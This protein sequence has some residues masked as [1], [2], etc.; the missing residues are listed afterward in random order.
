VPPSNVVVTIIDVNNVVIQGFRI[1]NGD[2]AGI[3][4][5]NTSGCVIQE[6]I[7]ESNSR[8]FLVF[9]SQ[10]ATISNNGFTDCGLGIYGN[11]LHHFL[12]TIENN[13]VNSRELFYAKNVDTVNI[14]DEE[15]YGSI[16]L[17]NC[18]N[19]VIDGQNHLS[20]AEMGVELAF[21]TD[22]VVKNSNLSGN[23]FGAYVYNCTDNVFIQDNT[24]FDNINGMFLKKS[25]IAIDNNDICENEEYGIQLWESSGSHIE[26]N[27][28][29]NNF[30]AGIYLQNSHDNTIGD[31]N[32]VRDNV[33]GI[34]LYS[35]SH[36]TIVN[37][38]ILRNTYNGLFLKNASDN[39]IGRN[40]IERNGLNP[41]GEKNGIELKEG[42]SN[43]IIHYNIIRFSEY[44]GLYI[45]ENSDGNLIYHNVFWYNGHQ[46]LFIFK[47][48]CDS[49]SNTYDNGYPE[50]YIP[51]WKFDYDVDEE[52]G[53]YW[54]DHLS[55]DTKAGPNQDE[56]Y[57]DDICDSPYPIPCGSN[58]DRYPLQKLPGPGL[59]NDSTPPELSIHLPLPGM[60]YILGKPIQIPFLKIPI[61]IDPFGTFTLLEADAYED[62][63]V[64]WQSNFVQV[65][66]KLTQDLPPFRTFEK[67]D[68]NPPYTWRLSEI[69]ATLYGKYLL[70]VNAT[71][72]AGNYATDDVVFRI[73]PFKLYDPWIP[74]FK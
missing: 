38:T 37:N 26:G 2:L 45:H 14:G 73:F 62:P 67:E 43:N 36:N 54:S 71:D 50:P 68:L 58:I 60:L 29:C 52:C 17:A 19:V 23:A 48:V 63:N 59:I 42:S 30:I 56:W 16:I 10:D 18:S 20:D 7:L 57:E 61:I 6:N 4:M 31:D 44:Y 25:S 3:W 34:D 32:M 33:D 72:A 15:D 46:W 64:E 1:I 27:V 51:G 9:Y 22:V 39:Y 65:K 55:I 8:G 40:V 47:Q 35:S 13:M 69:D 21:C 11:T 12:H 5:E 24:V 28:V 74:A 53:N 70:S 66:F 41:D 49:C